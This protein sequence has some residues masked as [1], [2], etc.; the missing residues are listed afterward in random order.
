LSSDGKV[1][2]C[3]YA[4]KHC[5]LALIG[6]LVNPEGLVSVGARLDAAD[7]IPKRDAS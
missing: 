3:S 5:C 4:F 1:G 7:L 6:G 2:Y